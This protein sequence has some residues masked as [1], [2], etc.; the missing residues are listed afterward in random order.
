MKRFL[1]SA[2][3]QADIDLIA[4]YTTETLGERQTDRY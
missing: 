4:A 2:E 1:V 3:A